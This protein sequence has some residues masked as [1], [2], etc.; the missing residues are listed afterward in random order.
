VIASSHDTGTAQSRAS[1]TPLCA[2]MDT[3]SRGAV[4]SCHDDGVATKFTHAQQFNGSPDVVMAML[5]DPDYV[6]EKCD[7]TGS[8]E[9]T[10]S[11]EETDDGGCVITSVRVLPAKV[12]SAAKKFVGETITVTETQRWTPLAADGSA[13]AEATVEFSAPMSFAAT[14]TLAGSDGGS[15]I[16]T[17]GAFKASVPFIGGSIEGS[18]A[19]LT[20]KYLDV[21]ESVGNEWL[22]R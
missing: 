6:T 15:V 17:S 13:S 2:S 9:T 12:P 19:E 7:R 11:I 20:T 22:A 8:L 21:E 1:R 10:A 5:R 4:A 16:T 14:I 18:A 3:L